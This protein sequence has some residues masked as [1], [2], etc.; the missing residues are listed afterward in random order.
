LLR[1]QSPMSDHLVFTLTAALGAMGDLAGH[2]RRGSLGWPGRSAIVGLLG[3][4]LGI[5]RDGNFSAL[6]GLRMAVA[7][8]DQG[9]PLRDYHTVET[10]PTAAAKRPQSRPDALRGNRLRTNTTISLRDYRMGALYAVTVWGGDLPPLLAALRRPAFALYLGRKSCPLAAPLGAQIVQA[11][12]AATA[13]AQ[14]QLPP[15]RAGAVAHL[16]IC[17]AADAPDANHFE[18]R[19]DAPLDRA[20]WHFAPRQVAFQAVHIAP[21]GQG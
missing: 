11:E 9:Q 7:V 17:D 6:D 16:L 18:Q 10:I 4:A 2:E 20:K 8:F 1:V 5:N 14:V 13:L 15:W 12:A 3:A 19:H 21:G